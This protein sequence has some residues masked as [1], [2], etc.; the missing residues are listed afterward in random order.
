MNYTIVIA[1][2]N[3]NIEW[4]KEFKNVIVYNKGNKLTDDI[5]QI[6]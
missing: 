3:E 5:N 4:T 6:F 1:R 2:Y